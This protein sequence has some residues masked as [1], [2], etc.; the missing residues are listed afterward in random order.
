MLTDKQKAKLIFDYME[1]P[2]YRGVAKRNG[3]SAS[4]VKRVIDENALIREVISV[5]RGS[6]P[7]SA[8]AYLREKQELIYGIINKCL[9]ILNDDEK[10]SCATLPQ[11]ASAMSTLLEKFVL[12]ESCDNDEFDTDPLSLSLKELGESLNRSDDDNIDSAA[13]R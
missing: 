6:A 4:T 2:S 1:N 12:S 3:V 13:S 10:L 9:M 5:M 11:I 7:S 8:D